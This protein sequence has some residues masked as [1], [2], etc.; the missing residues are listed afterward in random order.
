MKVIDGASQCETADVVVIGAGV[1]GAGLARDLSIR[2]LR[3]A[4]F[5]RNDIAF[6]ASGNSSGMIHGGARYLTQDPKVTAASCRDSGYIQ[7]IA[8]FLLFRIPFL[9]PIKAGV[10]GRVMM[11]LIDAFF[12]LYDRYQ[13]LKRG[14]LHTRLSPSDLRRIEPGLTGTFAGAVTFDEWGV[15]GTRMCVLN[16]VDAKER[17]ANVYV[18]TTVESIAR[19]SESLK[20]PPVYIVEARDRDTGARVRVKAKCVVNATG[21]WGPLTASLAGLA[22]ER[23]RLRPGKGIHVAFDR[24]ISNYAI[25][26]ES[27]DGRSIFLEPWQNMSVLGTT[28]TD[29]YGDLDDVVATSEEVR[30]LVEGVARVLPDLRNARATYT[31]AGV[32]PT[33]YSYGPIPDKLSREHAIIDH[34]QDHAP[35][36]YSMLGGKLASYRAFAEEMSDIIAQNLAPHTQ[37][38][39]H[40]LGLPGATELAG[41]ESARVPGAL[42][43]RERTAQI[44]A[45][46]KL[47]ERFGIEHLTARR[48]MLKHGDRSEAILR[49]TRER[50]SEAQVVCPCEAVTEAEIR[51]VVAHEFARSVDGVSRRTRLGLGPCGG[52]RCVARCAQ[53]VAD[54]RELAPETALRDGL[55]FFHEQSRKRVPVLNP[56]QAPQ[57]AFARSAYAALAGEQDEESR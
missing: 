24:R 38:R 20:G 28:D 45:E 9:M 30:Y 2:G 50:T 49:R 44:K 53:I 34:T 54:E 15:D 13:P 4:L 14:E 11:E 48:L 17:G 23:V 5:E 7:E 32:R 36:V 18:R 35:G 6:G 55:R 46:V 3:V 43:L 40:A 41:G 42:P 12:G 29:Y 56:A 57:E 22:S 37:C 10:K 31:W 19:A 33:L 26:A 51:H 21:A 39:T 8:P 16:V 47:A 52:V 25:W 27:I 1:N